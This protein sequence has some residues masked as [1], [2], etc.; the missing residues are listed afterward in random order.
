MNRFF[1]VLATLFVLVPAIGQAQSKTIVD[2]NYLLG[3][4][5]QRYEYPKQK[6]AFSGDLYDANSIDIGIVQELGKT[7]TI[8]YRF[9]ETALLNAQYFNQFAGAEKFGPQRDMAD[10]G[11][12]SQYQEVFAAFRHRRTYG[13]SLLLGATYI[14]THRR[15]AISDLKDSSIGMVVG[16][17]GEQKIGRLTVN[18]S[19]RFYPRLADTLRIKQTSFPEFKESFRADGYE[20]RLTATWSIARHVGLNTGYEFRRISIIMP[21]PTW[22]A[23]DVRTSKEFIIGTRISF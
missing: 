9:Q 16:I 1:I 4:S 5:E 20:L 22:S 3:N 12:N 18:Y 19:G 17:T 8:G 23:N 10:K 2:V 11:G 7:V 6:D 13:H 15:P 21:D 14:T